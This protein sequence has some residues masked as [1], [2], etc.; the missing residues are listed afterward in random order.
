MTTLRTDSN[1]AP[2]RPSDAI[3]LFAALFKRTGAAMI[4]APAGWGLKGWSTFSLFII[5]TSIAY[6]QKR[7]IEWVLLG[8][9]REPVQTVAGIG[10]QFGGGTIVI[11]VIVLALVGGYIF[12]R[13]N[14]VEAGIALAV[15][16]AW[17]GILSQ[18]GQFILAEAR[19]LQGGAMAFFALDGHGVSG[20]AASS[21]LLFWPIYNIWGRDSGKFKRALLGAI[22]MSWTAMVVWS[23]M[24]DGRHY[25]WNV[26]LGMGLG[27]SLGYNAVKEWGKI[28]PS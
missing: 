5:S 24:W 22:L 16:G 21:A 3:R 19:P 4:T 2:L 20:H 8:D 26:M 27:F 18:V 7:P 13:S 11:S 15:A 14:A 17:C 9:G 6:L 28:P 25:L 1:T 23:R 10:S 12:K